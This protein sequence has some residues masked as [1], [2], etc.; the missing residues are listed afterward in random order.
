MK[1]HKKSYHNPTLVHFMWQKI[2]SK[3]SS[4]KTVAFL[5]KLKIRHH[6]SI[7]GKRMH[8]NVK[9][10]PLLQTRIIT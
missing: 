7:R 4:V 10:V 2:F 3:N 9:I 5:K 1:R 6:F 8:L